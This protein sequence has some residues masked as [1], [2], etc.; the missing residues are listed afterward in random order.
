[1]MLRDLRLDC[2]INRSEIFGRDGN[3]AA[4]R[5]RER[6]GRSRQRARGKASTRAIELRRIVSQ[7]WTV[8]SWE[9]SVTG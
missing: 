4:V 3:T 6:L 9:E 8:G 7:I 2:A 5:R 1:M